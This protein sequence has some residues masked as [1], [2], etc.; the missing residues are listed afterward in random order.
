M[1]ETRRFRSRSILFF[2]P[3]VATAAPVSFSGEGLAVTAAVCQDGTCCPDPKS[4]CVV[5]DRVR[6]GKYYKSEGSCTEI[7]PS[8]PG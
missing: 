6:T 3:I 5:G 4:T 8:V 1:M 7:A 2:L